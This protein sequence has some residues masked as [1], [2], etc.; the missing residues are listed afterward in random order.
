G[1]I[2]GMFSSSG[3]AGAGEARDARPLSHKIRQSLAIR[4]RSARSCGVVVA[5]T[6]A[7]G[8]GVSNKRQHRRGSLSGGIRVCW[9]RTGRSPLIAAVVVWLFDGRRGLF[10][11]AVFFAGGDPRGRH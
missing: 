5:P 10:V 9:V 1:G 7:P 4:P 3:T 8:W 2:D 6:A 11:A